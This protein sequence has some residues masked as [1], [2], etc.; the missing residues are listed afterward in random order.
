MTYREREREREKERGEI[1]ML[2]V[3]ELDPNYTLL[4]I[5]KPSARRWPL[6]VGE[7]LGVIVGDLA[8]RV[9]NFFKKKVNSHSHILSLSLSLS[10]P[11]RKWNFLNQQ[12]L[13][14]SQE[15]KLSHLLRLLQLL[16]VLLVLFLSLF[17]LIVRYQKSHLF[18]HQRL[19]LLQSR[20]S[21]LL[22]DHHRILLIDLFQPEAKWI[23]GI[24]IIIFYVM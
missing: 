22:K 21:N 6:V 17:Q 15:I 19:H 5:H 7:V 8:I 24:V 11:N 18:H 2:Q 13:V 20:I 4:L 10:S 16:F 12:H 23:S 1:W 9:I 3:K 14:N